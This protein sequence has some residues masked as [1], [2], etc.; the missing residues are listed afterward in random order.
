M[1]PK[2]LKKIQDLCSDLVARA[3]EDEPEHFVNNATKMMN[4]V[5]KKDLTEA[6]I[7]SVNISSILLPLLNVTV[8]KSM[9]KNSPQSQKI[10]SA[11][12]VNL[13]KIDELE[14]YGRRENLRITGLLETEGENLKNK[15]IE[16]GKTLGVTIDI[17]DINVVHRVGRSEPDKTRQTIVRFVSRD[18]K[19]ELMMNKKK[20]K[21][22]EG[23]GRVY[24]NDDLTQLRSRLLMT[25]KKSDL[26]QSCQVRDGSI[27]CKLRD[28]SFCIVRSPD[29]LFKV[30]F[31]DVDLDKLGL[32][33]VAF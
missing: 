12:R 27:R 19:H 8:L 4:G 6:E 17:R 33:H 26:V 32:Q 21:D 18:K 25:L 10:C 22:C 28:G 3:E 9:E 24:L 1:P 30:G 13:Y 31:E 7:M 29:D 15:L 5:N 20:L 14:Q 23:Y 2:N 16:L 11:V